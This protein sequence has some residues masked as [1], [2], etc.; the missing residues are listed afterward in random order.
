MAKEHAVGEG[1][2][3]GV[4]PSAKPDLFEGV[5]NSLGWVAGFSKHAHLGDQV[6][7]AVEGTQ[8]F[9]EG[10]GLRAQ[11]YDGVRCGHRFILSGHGPAV[12]ALRLR[13]C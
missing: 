2:E 12:F 1:P 7:P 3:F 6:I 10:E 9:G 11:Q 4:C 5:V 13:E 8:F